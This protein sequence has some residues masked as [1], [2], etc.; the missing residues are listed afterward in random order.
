MKIL[1][2]KFWIYKYHLLTI[3]LFPIS[4]IFSLFVFLKKKLIKKLKFPIPVI[5]VGNIYVGGTGKTPLALFICKKLRE[6]GKNPAIIKKY[7]PNHRDEFEFLKYH[8]KNII[9]K[10]NREDA[11]YEAK[12]EG[13]DCVVLDDGFQDYKIKKDFQILC[14]NSKQL[15]GNGYVLPAGPLRENL[16]AVKDVQA[17]V[18]NGDYNYE[19]E[20]KISKI[21]NN[22]KIYYSNYKIKNCEK[23]LNKN[24]LAFAGIGNPSNFFDLLEANNIKLKKKISYPDHYEFSDIEIKNLIN[25]A[26]KNNLNIVTTE[27]DHFRIKKYNFDEIGFVELNLEFNS[28]EEILENI[29]KKI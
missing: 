23:F 18:I 5:C 24:F 26:K 2:P 8:F 13:Y 7:Y 22:L 15:I 12:K 3:L 4:L 14:F 28:N 19:F 21:N 27:K 29:L 10:D 1:K 20:R 6:K 16:S 9:I 25:D 11:I 17:I